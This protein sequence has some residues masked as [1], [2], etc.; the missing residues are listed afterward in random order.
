MNDYGEIGGILLTGETD[1]LGEKSVPLSL[2]PQETHMKRPGLE[3]R[4]PQ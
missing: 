1:V 4:L 2:S 3:P